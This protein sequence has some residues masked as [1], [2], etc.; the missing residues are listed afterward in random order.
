[1]DLRV[2][3]PRNAIFVPGEQ[4]TRVL[5]VDDD[6]LVAD[7]LALIVRGRGF[8]SRAA[9]CGEDAV[10][11]ALTWKPDAVIADVIMGKLDGVALATYLAQVLPSCK[12]LLIS[13]NLDA[14]ELM[15]ESNEPGH[16]FPLFAKP[17]HPDHIF[18]F[19]RSPGK[20]AST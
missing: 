10:D 12:V 18:E 16:T 13:G 20:S 9:Y 7:S 5:V 2:P 3:L 8:E 6:H 15:N 19:L 4:P 14:A 11:L 1:V 17:V